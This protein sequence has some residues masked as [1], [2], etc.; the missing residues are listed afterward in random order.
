MLSR[1]L[2]LR[3]PPPCP[4][5]SCSRSCFPS[6]KTVAFLRLVERLAWGRQ[7]HGPA[8]Q[9]AAGWPGARAPGCVPCG[10]GSFSPS[11][12]NTASLVLGLVTPALSIFLGRD[13]SSAFPVGYALAAARGMARWPGEPP[14]AARNPETGA[15]I[16]EVPREDRKPCLPELSCRASPWPL[17]PALPETR[18]SDRRGR[19]RFLPKLIAPIC[20]RHLAL[21]SAVRGSWLG[22]DNTFKHAVAIYWPYKLILVGV[23]LIEIKV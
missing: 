13:G 9:A 17:S 16:V 19:H 5:L 12:V 15:L 6:A 20:T 22:A 18:C 4:H 21:C 2:V 14:L 23:Q 10:R 7:C 3:P 11:R 1:H 8:H